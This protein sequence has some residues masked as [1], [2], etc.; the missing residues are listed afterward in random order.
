M[1]LVTFAVPQESRAFAESLHHTA[2]F[3]PGLLGNVDREEVAVVH[4]GMGGPAAAAITRRA[5]AEL[6]PRCVVSSGFAGGLS[7]RV[8]AGDVL[9]ASNFSAPKLLLHVGASVKPVAF[10]CTA[11]PV[12]GVAEKASLHASTGA[13]A[14]DLESAG[15][16]E[17]CE[18]ARV[19]VVVLR[20]VSD[21]PNEALPLPSNVAYDFER[22][23]VRTWAILRHL[24]DHPAS[25]APLVRFSRRIPQLQAIL[26]EAITEFVRESGRN[27]A[28]IEPPPFDRQH[29]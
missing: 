21:G 18:A 23:C 10:T 8:A 15:V 29:S 12:D 25:I 19:P 1:I 16:R 26:S 11:M 3:G 13:D 5:L 2:P 27:G 6:R 20:V 9:A 24:C 22:Q 14:V 7:P 17:A 28:A 4:T